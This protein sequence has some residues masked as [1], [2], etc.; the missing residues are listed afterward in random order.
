MLMRK[1]GYLLCF[2]VGMLSTEYG[3][4]CILRG[5]RGVGNLGALIPFPFVPLECLD[6]G[7]NC[8]KAGK[9]THLVAPTCTGDDS[10][11][12]VGFGWQKRRKGGKE[13]RGGKLDRDGIGGKMARKVETNRWQHSC[14]LDSPLNK[15]PLIGIDD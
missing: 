11:E 13:T 10:D 4:Y 1:C 14:S 2:K 3:L 15:V 8:G 9:S 6:S 7:V 5:K 12:W